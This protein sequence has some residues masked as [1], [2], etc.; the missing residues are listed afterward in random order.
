MKITRSELLD[1]LPVTDDEL[2]IRWWTRDDIDRIAGWLEY[3]P[4]YDIYSVEFTRMDRE[5]RDSLFRKREEQD[6]IITLVADYGDSKAIGVIA[7]FDVDWI[8][9]VIGNVGAR[10]AP[11]WCDRGIGARFLK[12][13]SQ[14]CFDRGIKAI[15]LDAATW[16]ARAIKCY[17]KAGFKRTGETFWR[18]ADCPDGANLPGEH[19]LPEGHVRI[20]RGILQ[21]RHEWLE[22]AV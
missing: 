2:T 14:W 16:N 12:R 22:L 11:E 17:E 15:R 20:E 21:V 1:S 3:P 8:E 7:L 19:G 5:Q 18:D 9:G 10:I 4:P 13:L 6:K